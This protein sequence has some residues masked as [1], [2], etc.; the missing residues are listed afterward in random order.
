MPVYKYNEKWFNSSKELLE[1]MMKDGI[2]KEV[3]YSEIS[4]LKEYNA[5]EF[6]RMALEH[7]NDETPPNL[8][9]ASFKLRLAVV[10]TVQLFYLNLSNIYLASHRALS[11]FYDIAINKMTEIPLAIRLERA[12]SCAEKLRHSSA[13]S[14]DE[15]GELYEKIKFFAMDF[16]KIEINIEVESELL[17]D[18]NNFEIVAFSGEKLQFGGKEYSPKYTIF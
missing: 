11:F 18:K 13:C 14:I 17:D 5:R 3:N 4:I 12:W 7:I 1:A 10:N 16:P 6:L 2:V 8:S 9:E 15:F